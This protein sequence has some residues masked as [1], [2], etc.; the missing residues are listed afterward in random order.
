MYMKQLLRGL[1][2]LVLEMHFLFSNELFRYLLASFGKQ[3][4][5][6]K[7]MLMSMTAAYLSY[8]S[9]FRLGSV[10]AAGISCLDSPSVSNSDS[11]K[12]FEGIDGR[13]H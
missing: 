8:L 7:T 9:H 5:S 3:K 11:W 4:H 10:A 1:L 2:T 6:S 12:V 13:Q